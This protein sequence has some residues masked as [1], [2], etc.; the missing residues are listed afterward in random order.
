MADSPFD[1]PTDQITMPEPP[2]PPP[3]VNEDVTQ[4]SEDLAPAP[5]RSPVDQ[6]PPDGES[7]PPPVD[8]PTGTTEPEE[9]SEPKQV[10]LAALHEEREKRKA[11]EEQTRLM[12][13]RFN[14]FRQRMEQQIAPKEE[15][16]E[17]G[18]PDLDEDPVSNLDARLKQQELAVKQQ[19]EDLA[20]QQ[21]LE[22]FT[23]GFQMREAE[24]ASQNPDYYDAVNHL[25]TQRQGEL[26][27]MGYNDQQASQIVDAEAINYAITMTQNG[28]DPVQT[29][30]QTAAQ[31]GY[32]QPAAPAEAQVDITQLSEN[33]QRAESIG[34]SGDTPSGAPTLAQLSEMSDDEFEAATSGKNWQKLWGG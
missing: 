20:Q 19:Q 22:Q 7:E 34:P 13:D 32:K 10:P 33:I 16:E 18:P 3:Q 9:G 30:Y 12:E 28:V 8:E 11:L 17:V 31:R 23:R 29:F 26:R 27:M 4:G 6:P 2:T 1:I 5:I 24:F 15:A 21:Q 25:R 14:E